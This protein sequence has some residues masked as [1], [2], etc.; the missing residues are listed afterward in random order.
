M[1]SADDSA[2]ASLRALAE[3]LK[4]TLTSELRVELEACKDEVRAARDE[5]NRIAGD[6]TDKSTPTSPTAPITTTTTDVHV[7]VSKPK[8]HRGSVVEATANLTRQVTHQVM[9]HMHT[10]RMEK[11]Q[12]QATIWDTV[13]LIKTREIRPAGSAF[14]VLLILVC[15]SVQTGFIYAL[16]NPSLK[17]TTPNYNLQ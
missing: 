15:I 4:G 10:Q 11:R 14:L 8:S 3:Q 16:L 2:E 1:L 12:L 13:L 7:D 17:L 6:A 5:L 9:D